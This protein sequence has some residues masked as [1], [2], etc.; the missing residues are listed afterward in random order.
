MRETTQNFFKEV[1]WKEKLNAPSFRT[2][3]RRVEAV[4]IILF[5]IVSNTT[6][7]P[8][9]MFRSGINKDSVELIDIMLLLW[10]QNGNQEYRYYF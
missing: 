1:T 4:K 7:R 9:E 8:F 5:F 3:R 2:S 10:L 6:S